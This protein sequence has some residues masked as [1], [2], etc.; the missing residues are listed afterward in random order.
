MSTSK[1]PKPLT[2]DVE[3]LNSSITDL[4]AKFVNGTA[5]TVTNYNNVTTTGVYHARGSNAANAPNT[6]NPG[7]WYP[8]MV[9][10]NV[11]G[12]NIIFQIVFDSSHSESKYRIYDSGTWSAWKALSVS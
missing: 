12:S 11:T 1:A 7:R 8:I 5:I 9:V 10:L 2:A 6:A 4:L 3:A